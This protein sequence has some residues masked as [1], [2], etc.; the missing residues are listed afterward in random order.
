MLTKYKLFIKEYYKFCTVLDTCKFKGTL[1]TLYFFKEN[2]ILLILIIVNFLYK[3]TEISL[4]FV[5]KP[6]M[7]YF[8]GQSY[9]PSIF[10]AVELGAVK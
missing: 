5:L 6:S 10:T 7:S 1:G 3:K 8:P 4:G 2:K 9:L